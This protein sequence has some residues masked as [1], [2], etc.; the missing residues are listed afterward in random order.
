[1]IGRGSGH[2]INMGSIGGHEYYPGGNVYC[3]TKH[4]V[5][6]ITKTLL[7]DLLGTPVCVSSIDPGAVE[8]E[9]SEVRW[10]DKERARRFY[11][12]FQPLHGEDIADA[13]VYCASRPPH[14]TV[15]EMIV[16]PT[17][18]ASA[19]HLYRGDDGQ[20]KGVLGE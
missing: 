6:A 18:Q 10:A 12:D 15:A 9:F 14:V 8:T 20:S 2:I 7:I 17:D 3:A 19:N 5:K 16:M 13:V 1:M 11:T 4:A